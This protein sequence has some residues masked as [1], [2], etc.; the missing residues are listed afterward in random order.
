MLYEFGFQ[1]HI[2]DLVKVGIFVLPFCIYL[3]SSI[4]ESK[5]VRVSIITFALLISIFILVVFYIMPVCSYLEIKQ[6]I[7]KGN[8]FI[9]EGEVNNFETPT[10]SWGGHNSESFTI[11]GVEFCYF[12]TENY[13]YSQFLCDGGVI[14]G[15][16]Q[17]LRITYCS[18]RFYDEL[19]ICRIKELD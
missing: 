5:V 13:G 15:N 1:F 18:D 4:F 2:S 3:F 8:V 16:G 12:G 17:K 19:V 10:S 14:T 11:D 7:N 6:N 9:V